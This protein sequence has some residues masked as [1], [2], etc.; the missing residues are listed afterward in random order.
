[1]PKM[2]VVFRCR[3]VAML[4][5]FV[6]PSETTTI[7]QNIFIKCEVSITTINSCLANQ[8]KLIKTQSWGNIAKSSKIYVHSTIAQIWQNL[9][10]IC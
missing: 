9:P 6:L 7:K 2:I 1:M 4:R 8:K 10:H 3:F 5:A